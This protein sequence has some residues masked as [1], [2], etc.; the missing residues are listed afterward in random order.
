MRSSTL[1]RDR[2]RFYVDI[3]ADVSL[4]KH[5]CIKQEVEINKQKLVSISGITPGECVTLGSISMKLNGLSCEAHV[6]PDNFP[7]DT[8]GL[9][10]WD[11]MTKH[12][13]KVNAANER[14]ETDHSVIPFEREEEFIIPPRTRQVIYA[15]VQ[16]IE[17]RVG[18]VPLQNL[19]PKLLF[20]NFVATNEEGKAY[21]L[22]YNISDEP[23][24]I[25]APVVTL[26]PCEVVREKDEVFG[27]GD[28]DS[29]DNESEHA[30]VL[31]IISEK[32][33]NRATRVFEALDPDTLKDLNAEEIAHIKELIR[34]RP[35]LFGLP[36]EGLKATH[37]VTHK[38]V[39]TTDTPV[40]VKRH[41]HP[42]AIKEEMQRQIT[43]Y[44][45][46]G[47]IKPSDSPYLSMM[48]VVPKKS[49]KNGEKRWRMVTD[50]RQ[51]NEITVDNSYQLP[52]TTDIIE[53]AASAKY[54]TAIDLKTGFYQIPMDPEDAHK[55]AFAGP[56]GHYEYTRMGMGLRNAPATFQSLMD[57]VLSGLQGVELYVYLD[58]II[59]FATD[60]EDHR[61]KFRRLMKRL[62]EAN[63]TV[64]PSK[65][66]FLQREP[67]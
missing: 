14:L 45:E 54:I 40:R 50:F 35:H 52:L 42:P 8:D 58:D 13:V 9:L 30:N 32:E 36:G 59:V 17:E 62:D 28:S 23:V 47:I 53:A 3:G 55:T 64:E 4:I 18:F 27:T 63:L 24:K 22:C 38:V 11:M 60:L 66:Q 39:T 20:G 31:R 51:L 5:K 56:Y 21:A 44:L 6:V 65:C 7:I 10:G 49:R 33:A 67:S 48:W 26:E 43:Q 15:R 34:E 25:A 2:G 29:Y 57:L 37:L 1:N 16:N 61:K 12:G 46:A 19:G 41:R